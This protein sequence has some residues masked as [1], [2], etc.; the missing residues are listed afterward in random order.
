MKKCF[1]CGAE[2]E[3]AAVRCA[4]CGR[5]G[6]DAIAPATSTTAAATADQ[7]PIPTFLLR[8]LIALGVWLVVSAICTF[9]AWGNASDM[10]VGRSE[11]IYTWESLESFAD[12]VAKYHQKFHTNPVSVEDFLKL[13]NY[14]P[15]GDTNLFKD[16]W[17]HP[18]ILSLKA[19][20]PVLTSYGRDGKPGGFGLDYDLSSTNSEPAEATPTFHQFLYDIAPRGMLLSCIFCGALAFF[21]CLFTIRT[22]DL[23]RAGIGKLMLKLTVTIC[24]VLMTAAVISLLHMMVHEH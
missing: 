9:V 13:T 11:Q 8:L 23:S 2:N 19:G 7:R 18:F 20:T 5:P 17:G 4:K 21:I 10:Y 15:Y 16:G 6:F 3:D 22:P 24:A 1:S 12:N 14:F